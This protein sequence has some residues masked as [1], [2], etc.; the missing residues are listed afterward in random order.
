MAFGF[1]PSQTQQARQKPGLSE[2]FQRAIAPG[3]Q[4]PAEARAD[5]VFLVAVTVHLQLAVQ[6]PVLVQLDLTT[7]AAVPLAIRIDAVL[8]GVIFVA[9]QAVDF[10]V[11]AE[12]SADT[13]FSAVAVEVQTVLL[14]ELLVG[15][16]GNE[17]A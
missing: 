1:A 13:G 5:G 7:Q 17:V 6:A 12:G 3:Q 11:G 14:V 9:D 10:G 15:N 2:L 8:L 4:L 16:A